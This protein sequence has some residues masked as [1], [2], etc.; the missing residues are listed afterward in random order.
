ML[1]AMY[2]MKQY[3]A[4]VDTYLKCLEFEK[5]QAHLGDKDEARQHNDAVDI[6]TRVANEFNEQVRTY[7][8]KSG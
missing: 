3:T 2:T 6:A 5:K 8:S 1:T 4:D 7:K